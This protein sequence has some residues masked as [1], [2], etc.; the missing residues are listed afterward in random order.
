MGEERTPTLENN[1]DTEKRSEK[2]FSHIPFGLPV[3]I[4]TSLTGSVNFFVS[5][6][7]FFLPVNR[8][9]IGISRKMTTQL[10]PAEE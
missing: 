2:R 7:T 10:S 6:L 1:L 9:T 5:Q 3:G 4:L 8:G